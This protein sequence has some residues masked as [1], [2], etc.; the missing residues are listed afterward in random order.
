MCLR[1]IHELTGIGI[2]EVGLILAVGPIDDREKALIKAFR[3]LV[4][5]SVLGGGEV[6]IRASLSVGAT[7]VALK[8]STVLRVLVASCSRDCSNGDILISAEGSLDLGSIG[9]SLKLLGRRVKSL[10]E[11]KSRVL[12]HS[13]GG[14]SNI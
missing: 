8:P 6:I 12:E 10:Q 4:Y 5:S 3:V 1:F 7:T 13:V 14:R 9:K 11:Y 2:L